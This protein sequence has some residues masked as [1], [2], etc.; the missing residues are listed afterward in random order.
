LACLTLFFAICLHGGFG[1]YD[2]SWLMG[3]FLVKKGFTVIAVS[4]PGYLGTPIS[5]GSTIEQQADATVALMDALGIP[6]AAIYGFS[7]GSLVAFQVGVRHPER[8]SSVVLTGVGLQEN[9]AS[10]YTLIDLFLRTDVGIDIPAY[11][12]YLLSQLDFPATLAILMAVDTQLTGAAYDERFA[13]VEGNKSQRQWARDLAVS[14]TPFSDRRAGSIADV[15]AVATWPA[16]E[17]AGAFARFT[18]PMLIVDARHDNSGS[19]P[20]TRRIA[21]KIH[22]SRL[23]SV[24][25]SGHFIWLGKNTSKWETQMIRY[26]RMHQD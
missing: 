7:A 10:G 11:G 2:Q 23:I 3:S 16:Y 18:P 26:L 20:Q 15:E 5:V 9:Q 4:R 21:S 13:Y 12:L 14:L 8:C 1:G 19:Y 17:K 25:G 22:T 24:E 6:K